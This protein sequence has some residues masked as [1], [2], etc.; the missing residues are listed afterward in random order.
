MTRISARIRTGRAGFTMIELLVV[1]TIIVI[2]VAL[3]AAA[4][5]RFLASSYT[6]TTRTTI[7]RFNSRLQAQYAAIIDRARKERI[8]T[9]SDAGYKNIVNDAYSM[10]KDS[11]NNISTERARVI[12]VKFRLQQYFP[13]AFTEV[14]QPMSGYPP[15][16]SYV[17]FLS[18]NGIPT[19][20]LSASPSN[21]ESAICLYM[22]LRYG[23]DTTGEDDLGLGASSKLLSTPVGQAP[24]LIDTWGRALTF[25]RWPIGDTTT[26][27]PTFIS[28]VNPNGA[29]PGYNDPADPKGQLTVGTWLTAPGY[30]GKTG[31]ATLVHL[32]PD[33][34]PNNV[35]PQSQPRSLNLAPVIAS[36]GADG[37]LGLSIDPNNSPFM[38]LPPPPGRSSTANDNVY[39]FE[40]K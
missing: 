14:L 4:A 17:N 11:S 30:N 36:S 5:F 37:N 28:P 7:T 34:F 18:N 9:S 29:S 16:P 39:S 12:H 19:G 13:M 25:C 3:S 20:P 38:V 35:Q 32:L 26:V 6:S 33:R 40:I 31:F 10:S 27:P 2:L 1:L 8:P 24:G 21:N 23:P 15:I 22:I